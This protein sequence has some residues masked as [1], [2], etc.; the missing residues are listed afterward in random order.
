GEVLSYQVPP[1][2]DIA[3]KY[4]RDVLLSAEEL[5]KFGPLKR[6][7]D[8]PKLMDKLNDLECEAGKRKKQIRDN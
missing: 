4:P 7:G 5:E 6:I 1:D 2:H 8:D 3:K